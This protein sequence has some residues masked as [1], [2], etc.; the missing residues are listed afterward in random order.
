MVFPYYPRPEED[1][2]EPEEEQQQQDSPS[3]LPFYL[4]YIYPAPPPPDPGYVAPGETHTLPNGPTTHPNTPTVYTPVNP[5]PPTVGGSGYVF[6][7]ATSNRPIGI[8]PA[9]QPREDVAPNIP[10][11]L[12]AETK[13]DISEKEVFEICGNVCEQNPQ[14]M[15]A[16]MNIIEGFDPHDGEQTLEERVSNHLRI[17]GMNDAFGHGDWYTTRLDPV[18]GSTAKRI[19]DY[20]F[21]R[22]RDSTAGLVATI[23]LDLGR[24]KGKIDLEDLEGKLIRWNTD[25]LAVPLKEVM[26]IT[27]SGE[28]FHM[29][30]IWI[31]N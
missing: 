24:V 19:V 3:Y 5:L 30:H 31:F 4:S 9:E 10:D 20:Y 8:S 2:P 28:D 23:A 15:T 16:V 22:L 7:D 14:V 27:R 21:G 6:P 11:D 1:A 29:K 26:V 25:H 17:M 18:V 13:P 12:T